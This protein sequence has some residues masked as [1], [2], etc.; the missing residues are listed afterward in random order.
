MTKVI[1][2]SNFKSGVGK[3]ANAVIF[4]CTLSK[5]KNRVLILD[6]DPQ[7]NIMVLLLNAMI[8]V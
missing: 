6:L 4:S 7:T 1:T 8:S 5:M 2:T 3:A